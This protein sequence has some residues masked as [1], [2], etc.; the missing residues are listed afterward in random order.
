MPRIYK[1]EKE[2]KEY[3]SSFLLILIINKKGI[4][5]KLTPHAYTHG[6]S[7]KVLLCLELADEGHSAIVDFNGVGT[8]SV[9][10]LG[11]IADKLGVHY[12]ISS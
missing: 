1:R 7:N 2:Q 4:H 10:L 9:E 12:H 3:T 5:Q 6:I 8:G 11:G